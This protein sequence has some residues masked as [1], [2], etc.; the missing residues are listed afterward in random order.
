MAASHSQDMKDLDRIVERV[1]GVMQR[2]KKENKMKELRDL[3]LLVAQVWIIEG[4]Y[5][6][7]LKMYQEMVNEEPRDFR[8]YLCQG[9]V[10]T[11]M[12]KMDEADKNFKQ[13]RKLVPKNHPYAQLFE[14]NLTGINAAV[15]K[16]DDNVKVSSLQ[17]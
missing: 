3:K 5:E 15:K 14:K 2:C 4:K 12:R 11:L 8:P 10:Y 7:A 6:E 17:S 16:K 9:I 13:Y 1:E